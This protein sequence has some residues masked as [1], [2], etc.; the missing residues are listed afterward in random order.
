MNRLMAGRLLR[1]YPVLACPEWFDDA[2]VKSRMAGWQAGM[3]SSRR[4]PQRPRS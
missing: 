2:A 4:D 1:Q 3:S